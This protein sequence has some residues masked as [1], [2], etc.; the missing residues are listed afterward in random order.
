MKGDFSRLTYNPKDH[1]VAVLHQQ[2]RVFLDS[3]WNADVLERLALL[4]R[5]LTDVIG[6]CGVPEPGTAFEI[7]PGIEPNDFQVAAGRCYVHGVLCLLESDTT[8]LS[9]PDLLDPPAITIPSAGSTAYGLVYL[10]VWHRLITYL[11]DDNVREIALNGPDTA[12]RLKT[13]SQIKILPLPNSPAD[14]SL[15]NIIRFLP[16]PGAGTLTTL[17]PVPAQVPNLCQLPD[18]GN[19]T[20]RQNHLYRVQIHDGGEVIGGSLSARLAADATRGTLTLKLANA[21]NSNQVVAAKRASIVTVT[22]NVT[23]PEVIALAGTSSDGGTLT[24]AAPLTR[25]YTTA[26]N[27][28][29]VLG[30][31]A[32]FKWSRENAS[33]AVRVGAVQSDR[34]TLTLASLGRDTVTALRQGDLVEI[35]DD[36]SEL[37]R[38]QGHLTNLVA[39]P[40]PDSL[41]VVLQDPLPVEFKVPGSSTSTPQADRHL[42]LRRWDGLGQA[43]AVYGDTATPAMNLGDGIHIQF[44]GSDLRSGDYWQFTTRTA[45]GSVE[46]LTDAPPAGIVRHWCPLAVLRWA[47]PALHSPPLS[48][49]FGV[50]VDR[51]ADY[52]NPFPS[53]IHFP[54][55]E[56]GIHITGVS[57]VDPSGKI[58]LPLTNDTEVPVNSFGRIDIQCDAAIDPSSISRP[59]CFLALEF[60]EQTDSM[61]DVSFYTAISPPGVASSSANIISWQ[62][63]STT[64]ALLTQ[65]T[66]FVP[67]NDKGVLTRLTLKGNFIWDLATQTRYLDGDAFGI[68]GG[69]GSNT[70]LAL[71][72]GDKRRG[73]DFETWFW[74]VSAPPPPVEVAAI[75]CDPSE[76]YPANTATTT[77]TITLSAAPSTGLPITIQNRNPDLV[78]LTNPPTSV[79]ARLSSITFTGSAVGPSN[80]TGPATIA[81]AVGKSPP[82]LNAVSTTLKVSNVDLSGTLSLLP[83]DGHIRKGGNVT[84]NCTLTGAAPKGTPRVTLTSSAPGIA[85]VPASIGIPVGNT[86]IPEFL[87]H[88]KSPGTATITATLGGVVRAAQVTVV[89]E[90][91]NR[92]GDMPS[93]SRTL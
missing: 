1:Y 19:F 72:S 65:L 11:E 56:P 13:I 41:T 91:G 88:G 37:S 90:L 50:V 32:R 80:N 68:P 25:N 34:V 2:G 64:I 20:G 75:S 14:F 36:W 92:F 28:S 24:L 47:P 38:A 35:S 53:L 18:P 51:I 74:L 84:V 57:I 67:P 76:I 12:T 40:D 23:R 52:R 70:S 27:A 9:Q 22:D 89:E 49:P 8:Y 71:P 33:F 15:A 45:D 39:D 63:T 87:I 79:P 54:A 85:S 16:T 26:N 93:I 29:V 17:Q 59:T 78:T 31:V 43:S 42:L 66:S 69:G 83:T 82:D 30:S 6:N 3:D 77:F 55:V 44:G 10:E 81:A 62:P 4:R 5:E 60:A 46:A 21:L 61:G 86:S 7:S 48:P 73:G 58:S